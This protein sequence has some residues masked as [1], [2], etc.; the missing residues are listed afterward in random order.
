MTL[1]KQ[2]ALRCDGINTDLEKEVSGFFLHLLSSFDT[3]SSPFGSFYVLRINLL[4]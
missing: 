2:K 4:K 3:R 1:D